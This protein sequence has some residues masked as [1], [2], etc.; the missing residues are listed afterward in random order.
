QEFTTETQ[1]DRVIGSLSD[2]ITECIFI[3][4]SPQSKREREM[5]HKLARPGVASAE[6]HRRL[7]A[8]RSVR[9]TIG[10]VTIAGEESAPH[11]IGV[12]PPQ[13]HP[14]IMDGPYSR[15]WCDERPCAELRKLESEVSGDRY[16]SG[17]H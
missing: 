14:P 2:L 10:K 1:R 16:G 5:G 4:P 9:A 15:R 17:S 7:F 3:K 8:H 13:T 11:L 12:C 6:G